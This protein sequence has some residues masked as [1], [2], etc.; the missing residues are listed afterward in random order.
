[1]KL[2]FVFVKC[3]LASIENDVKLY[4]FTESIEPP[5]VKTITFDSIQELNVFLEFSKSEWTRY[6]GYVMTYKLLSSYLSIQIDYN[7]NLI[8]AFHF[9]RHK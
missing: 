6:R 7:A 3:F 4:N 5:N 8:N 1:M 2:L 9:C